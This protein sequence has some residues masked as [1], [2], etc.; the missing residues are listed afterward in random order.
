MKTQVGE[1]TYFLLIA[2][3]GPCA[4]GKSCLVE[5]LRAY[6]YNAR[7]VVQEHS[8]VPTMWQRITRPDF[9]IY[10][11]VS[12]K[13]ACQRR[14]WAGVDDVSPSWWQEQGRRLAHAREHADLYID[15]DLLSIQAVLAEALSFLRV[16]VP[17]S[18]GRAT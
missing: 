2:V 13:V 6:G 4:S 12:W 3:V 9:L 5:G 16:Y 11:D 7:E 1:G 17:P 8:Y 10:L 15:T 14:L 18:Q